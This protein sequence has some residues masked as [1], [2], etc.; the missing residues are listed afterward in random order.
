MHGSAVR[1]RW[2]TSFAV[3][4]AMAA[5]ALFAAPLVASATPTEP[6]M[7]LSTLQARLSAAPSGTVSGYLKTVLQGTT[8]STIP[9]T[10]LDV[11]SAQSS[12]LGDTGSGSYIVFQA[13]GPVI[14]RLGAIA[15]GMSGS[16]IYVPDAGQDKLIGAL[17]Y[18]N[19]FSS[20]GSGL[21]T[22]IES[23]MGL[24]TYPLFSPL[25]IPSPGPVRVAL[26]AV[27]AQR[28]G[29]P[30][31]TARPLSAI[32]IGGLP[33]NAPGVVAVRKALAAK[34]VDLLVGSGVS[35]TSAPSNVATL[36]GGASVAALASRGDV[37]VGG[38]GTV[39]YATPSTVVAF[40]HPMFWEGR[41]NLY[42]ANAWIDYTWPNAAEPTKMG[43]PTAL[44]GTIEQDRGV[45]IMGAIGPVPAESTITA[46]ATDSDSGRTASSATYMLTSLL[47]SLDDNYV[48]IPDLA[49]YAAGFDV[50][51]RVGVTG[52]AQTT[53]TVVVRDG[54]RTFTIVRTDVWDAGAQDV[55]ASSD[56]ETALVGDV[57]M[58]VGTLQDLG[59]NGISHP[60]ILSVDLKSSITSTRA[61]ATIADVSLTAPLKIGANHVKVLLNAWGVADTQTVDATLTLPPGTPLTG[62]I[63]V[64]GGGSGSSNDSGF[65]LGGGL[66][67]GSSGAAQTT[68]QGIDAIDAT[69]RNS[70]IVIDYTPNG[71]SIGPAPD[72]SANAIEAT[73]STQWFVS[74]EVQKSTS[75]VYLDSFPT[76]L[77][78]NGG[79]DISGSVDMPGT[80]PGIVAVFGQP[81]GSSVVTTLAPVPLDD[82]A[83]F[84]AF[85]S[86]LTKNTLVTVRYLGDPDTLPSQATRQLYVAA[87]LGMK[88]SA[89]SVKH[90]ARITFTAT[91]L[92]A[93]TAGSVVFEYQSGRKWV[94]I[95]SATISAAKAALAWKVPKGRFTVRARYSGSINHGGTSKP[96]TVT[97]K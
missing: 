64:W 25:S 88:A 1:T 22:P 50:E 96:L 75:K 20:D 55:F 82:T 57:S 39:T 12:G 91:P 43:A 92:P 9:V 79:T 31:L 41:S 44:R 34:G 42:M 16:P 77:G 21:A 51:D 86:G 87:A 76:V 27:A 5:G 81:A 66:G 83:S 89:G 73:S 13:T 72:A 47:S 78:Y 30:S 54:V 67:A 97:G 35:G 10:V 37:W 60:Q 62:Q 18:G 14:D 17:S 65:G 15:A 84:E 52:S 38:I 70:D 94:S 2:F 29:T 32:E 71:G 53:T 80:V 7:T 45:G 49:T 11:A 23:M 4:A 40:G 19:E 61:S 48:A 58:V 3:I 26:H 28:L 85:V 46:S 59:T 90:G 8:I 36:E 68:S 6:I 74:G 95:G 33:S 69:P 93:D 24:S 56:L 63:D